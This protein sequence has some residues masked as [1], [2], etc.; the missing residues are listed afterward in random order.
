VLP[1]RVGWV[2]ITPA[3]VRRVIAIA[4]LRLLH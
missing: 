3:P 1:A 2:V 4:T